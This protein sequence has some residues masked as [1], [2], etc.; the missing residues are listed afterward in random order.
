M[1]KTINFSISMPSDMEERI[2]SLE[3]HGLDVD[4]YGK[5]NKSYLLRVVLMAGLE[6]LE[7]RNNDTTD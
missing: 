4:E 7:A 6:T 2:R 5:K 3:A 1:K